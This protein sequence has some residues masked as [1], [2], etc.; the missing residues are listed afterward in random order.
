MKKFFFPKNKFSETQEQILL[1]GDYFDQVQFNINQQV[2][3]KIK[4]FMNFV[5]CT[6]SIQDL[7]AI[8]TEKLSKTR[9]HIGILRDI[10][11]SRSVRINQQ[12]FKK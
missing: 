7:I 2:N 4:I 3:S 1:L 12:R 8:N 10:I 6:N 5:Q 9:R 11:V